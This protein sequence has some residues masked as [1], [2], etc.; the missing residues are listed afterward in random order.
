MRSERI[1]ALRRW[2]GLLSA[3]RPGDI[4]VVLAGLPEADLVAVIEVADAPVSITVCE[5][6]LEHGSTSALIALAGRAV[7]KECDEGEQYLYGTVAH[8]RTGV[9]NRIL[10]RRDPDVD[11]AIFDL[12][13]TV[14]LVG[15]ARRAILFRRRGHDGRASIPPPVKQRL[16]DAVAEYAAHAARADGG[17]RPSKLL[18]ELAAA[19]DA[20][21]VLAVLPYHQHLTFMERSSAV[22]ALV[23]QGRRKEVIE[24]Y[25]EL[26]SEC[27]R[28]VRRLARKTVRRAAR[29]YKEGP[30][31]PA[32]LTLGQ[33]VKQSKKRDK[34]HQN[35]WMLR[36]FALEALRTGTV[37]AAEAVAHSRPAAVALI[38][39]CCTDRDQLL[40]GARRAAADMRALIS[41]QLA[42]GVGDD[43]E[44]WAI[45]IDRA[46]G[47]R[48]TFPELLAGL[49]RGFPPQSYTHNDKTVPG[50]WNV[51][52]VLFAMAPHDV[53]TYILHDTTYN[54]HR[55]HDDLAEG[56][57]LT[58]QLVEHIVRDGTAEQR[59][60][61]AGNDA[62]PDSVLA[63]LLEHKEFV[64]VI[65]ERRHVAPE[66]R[67]AALVRLSRDKS[68]GSFTLSIHEVTKLG[69]E[70]LLSALRTATD[71]AQL[72]S[73]VE[74]AISSLRP[75]V[76]LATY[77]VLAEFVGPEAVWVLELD[78]AG[79]TEEMAPEVRAS[80]AAGTSEALSRATFPEPGVNDSA[81]G[82]A[83]DVW[84]GDARLDQP[85]AQPFETLA[86]THLDGRPERWLALADLL[87]AEPDADARELVARLAA[88]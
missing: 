46:A 49:D 66:I 1:S 64:S 48:G 68:I 24:R 7:L 44:R 5:Y 19:D 30:E 79:S 39:A 35:G 60:A 14:K 37:T 23:R 8:R 69:P 21:L 84:R 33:Y 43:P 15:Q 9:L 80:M 38:L 17:P 75:E 12:D 20:D 26:W 47:F 86:Q 2:A 51:T 10:V 67:L 87:T 63:R 55:L 6:V 41:E 25:P 65:A 73:V 81:P 78:R 4:P 52:N 56:A 62:T 85:F 50:P 76:R 58:R 36:H 16:L 31:G 13:D 29:T 59:A 42:A 88:G 74:P 77:A 22:A 18:S 27:S 83:D 53:A 34:H 57:P 3:A 72:V 40:P 61:L 54:R 32:A 71:P 70:P 28:A 11:A 82:P 45:V